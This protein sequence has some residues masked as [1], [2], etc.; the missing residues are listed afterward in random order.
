[1]SLLNEASYSRLTTRKWNIVND[2]SNA[3]YAIGNEIIYSLEVLK[4]NLFGCNNAYILVRGGI[5]VVR[6]NRTKVAFKNFAPFIKYVTKSDG[7]TI[8]YSKDLVF[9]M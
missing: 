4:S 9:V 5:T 1:M 3:N 7:A 6:D 2:Q 8:H